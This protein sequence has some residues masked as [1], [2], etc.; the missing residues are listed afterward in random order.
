MFKKHNLEADAFQEVTEQELFE[1]S[2]LFRTRLDSKF[3]GF[4]QI[5]NLLFDKIFRNPESKRGL[6]KEA[7]KRRTLHLLLVNYY[8]CFCNSVPLAIPLSSNFYTASGHSYQDVIAVKTFLEQTGGSQGIKGNRFSR[9]CGVNWAIGFLAEEFEKFR[10]DSNCALEYH[11]VQDLVVL[12]DKDKNRIKFKSSKVTIR[13]EKLLN[14]YNKFITN[15]RVGISNLIEWSDNLYFST[16][17]L[18]YL[19]NSLC[20]TI[21]SI[22]FPIDQLRS[23]QPIFLHYN[24]IWERL[25]N[26]TNKT[27]QLAALNSIF[28]LFAL[29]RF[30]EVHQLSRMFNNSTI[31]E[32]GRF[33]WTPIQSLPKELRS[34]VTINGEETIELDYSCYH[35]SILYHKEGLEVPV[36]PYI[37]PHGSPLREIMKL[38]LNTALNIQ[39]DGE[40]GTSKTIFSV[41]AEINLRKPRLRMALQNSTYYRENNKCYY[42]AL[43]EMYDELYTYH[44]P[45]QKAFCSNE[46]MKLQRIDSDIAEEILQHFTDRQVPVIPIHDSFIV[47]KTFADDLRQVMKDVYFRRF[48]KPIEV[49]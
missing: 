4:E 10:D 29:M 24:R 21:K 11:P 26:K 43:N 28:H 18:E 6:Y 34:A 48:N 42:S 20:L 13:S 41:L 7:Q 15:Q 1:L 22:Y 32:G 23:N 36:D 27:K 5:G 44:C 33:Y 17:S 12:K 35:T 49:K 37:H 30:P 19:Y 16:Q 25:L 45:I 14:K 8:Y 38:I 46:G 39:E 2:V 47:Q 3:Q 40:C 9:R 31:D